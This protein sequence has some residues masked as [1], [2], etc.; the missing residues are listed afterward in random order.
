MENSQLIP[1]NIL[2][3]LNK[4]FS[5]EIQGIFKNQNSQ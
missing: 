1:Q 2:E 4:N 5:L 3:A